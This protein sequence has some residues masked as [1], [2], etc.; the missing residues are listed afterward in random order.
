[1]KGTASPSQISYLNAISEDSLKKNGSHFGHSCGDL[2]AGGDGLSY[3]VSR[4]AEE[5]PSTG[6][7]YNPN[8]AIPPHVLMSSV[9]SHI[10]ILQAKQ[11]E[12]LQDLAQE[13]QADCERDWV[14]LCFAPYYHFYI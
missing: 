14:P 6:T 7:R 10:E 8:T 1:M 2:H 3:E 4:P 9:S 13:Q 5:P 11:L 12:A